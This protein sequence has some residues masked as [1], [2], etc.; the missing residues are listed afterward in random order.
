M[1][2]YNIKS[3]CL[4]QNQSVLLASQPL[5]MS[6]LNR[7]KGH[8][9]LNNTTILPTFQNALACSSLM[10]TGEICQSSV[11]F[12]LF[13]IFAFPFA[14]QYILSS[15]KRPY[16]I[17]RTTDHVISCLKMKGVFISIH[18]MLSFF[19]LYPVLVVVE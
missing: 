3:F 14:R 16:H 13:C 10:P 4:F 8:T 11:K 18:R 6:S 12:K 7:R 5:P 2:I 19:L 9:V 15:E 17:L 1:V